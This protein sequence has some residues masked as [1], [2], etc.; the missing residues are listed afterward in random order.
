MPPEDDVDHSMYLL[1]RLIRCAALSQSL[2][3]QLGLGPPDSLD[4]QALVHG[5]ERVG[6]HTTNIANSVI[7]LV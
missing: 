2:A 3:D 4:Y 1:R 7:A 6:D 5:I